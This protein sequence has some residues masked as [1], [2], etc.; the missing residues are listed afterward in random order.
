MKRR[1]LLLIIIIIVSAVVLPVAYF[2]TTKQILKTVDNVFFGVTYG[3]N[4]VEG[5]ELLINKVQNYTNVFILD[6]SSIS[7]N[8]SE[9]NIVCNYAAEKNLCFF[10]Y[11]FSLYSAEWQQSWVVNAKQTW[12]DK[13]LGV[14]LRDEPGG[15]QI[16]LTEDF[17]N[18]SNYSQAAQQYVQDVSGT[19]SMQFLQENSVPAVTSDYALYWFDYKAGF[20]T[21]FVELGLTDNRT[22]QIALCRGAA[23]VEG[24]SWGA[25]ITLARQVPLQMESAP[26]TYEDMLAAYKAGAK[27]ILMFDYPNGTQTNQQGILND[28][29]FAEMQQFWNYAK[30]N[31]L[32]LAKT[33]AQ[34]VF[35]L[36]QDYGWGLR[37][38]T[39]NIW[40]IWPAD[41]NSALIWQNMNFLLEKYELKL[42]T[43]Y[44]ENNTQLSSYYSKLYYWNQTLH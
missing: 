3:Q 32:D 15:R 44:Q 9:L 39:D 26:E 33:Q 23:N 11:F 34:V 6:S 35:V 38:V 4:T 30:A 7:D 12:G 29:Y 10:V 21:V 37:T 16:D 25:I 41:N 8:E 18:A 24:K 31:P 2:S 19:W 27:Y 1:G 20:N 40:G 36:P 13:F 22:E 28:E 42:D 14:Y 17:S 5:A 43:V